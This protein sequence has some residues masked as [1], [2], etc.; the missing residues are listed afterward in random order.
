MLAINTYLQFVEPSREYEAMN[1]N[2]KGKSVK[3]LGLDCICGGESM[4]DTARLCVVRFGSLLILII[5]F[6]FSLL[7]TQ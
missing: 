4:Y 3:K 6:V 2:A 7:H 5:N 1:N